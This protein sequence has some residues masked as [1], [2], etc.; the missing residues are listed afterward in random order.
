[1]TLTVTHSVKNAKV[2]LSALR[3]QAWQSDFKTGSNCVFSYTICWIEH[4]PP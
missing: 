1:M 4:L 2:R 3:G